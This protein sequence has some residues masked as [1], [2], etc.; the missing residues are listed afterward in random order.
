[1]D[2]HIE[3]A[4]RAVQYSL[5]R[6][7]ILIISLSTSGLIMSIG[8]VKD[9]VPDFQTVDLRLLKLTWILFSFAL[10]ANLISQVSGY[11]A[12]KA[13]IRVSINLVRE[14]RGKE[15]KGNQADNLCKRNLLS[16]TTMFINGVCLGSLIGGLA[17]LIAFFLKTI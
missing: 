1:M 13:E 4:Q 7:D 14:E 16:N 11:Y 2:K 10:V 8:F 12:N 6:F 3:S 9:I 17:T 5:E 15:M